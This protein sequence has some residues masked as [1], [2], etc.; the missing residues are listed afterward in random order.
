MQGARYGLVFARVALEAELGGEKAESF[1]ARRAAEIMAAPEHR[2][3]RKTGELSKMMDLRPYLVAMTEYDA[4]ARAEVLRAGLVGDLVGLVVTTDITP[5]GAARPS[6]LAEL[7]LG[8]LF[9]RVQWKGVRV[10]LVL[11]D[12]DTAPDTVGPDTLVP[13]TVAPDTELPDTDAPDTIAP[14]TRTPDTEQQPSGV[15][16]SA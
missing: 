15:A 10:A 12:P 8:D 7:V 16:A 9:D 14:D 2:I 13:D 6:E 3:R 11:R 1:L 4:V 5:S